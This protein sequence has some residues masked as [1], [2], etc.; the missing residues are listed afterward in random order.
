MN[1]LDTIVPEI[2]RPLTEFNQHPAAVLDVQDTSFGMKED[3]TPILHDLTLS[4]LPL[5]LTLILGKI[6][7][8]KST[9]LKGLIGEL[10]LT[11]GSIYRNFSSSAYCEQQPWLPNTSIQNI[12]LGPLSRDVLWYDTVI[13][14]CA[15]DRDFAA[16]PLGD[17]TMVGSKGVAISGGQ[18]ARVVSLLFKEMW[19][20][21]DKRNRLLQGR[22]TRERMWPLLMICLVVWI[23]RLKSLCGV[24]C[25]DQMAFFEDMVELWF[26]LLMPVSFLYIYH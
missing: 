21:T 22:Y 7:S 4:I 23:G 20:G 12:I 1:S 8:G 25:L 10:P 15:L 6:G 16:L 14:A 19:Y 2:S 9:L 3:G 24:T 17:G 5:T 11:T 13:K 18:K 26:W